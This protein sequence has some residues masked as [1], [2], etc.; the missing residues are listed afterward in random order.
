MLIS[1]FF[2]IYIFIYTFLSLDLYYIIY[3]IYF[4]DNKSNNNNNDNIL[5]A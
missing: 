3:I 2:L 5:M 1:K 4:S